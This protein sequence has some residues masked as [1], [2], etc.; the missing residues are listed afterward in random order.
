MNLLVRQITSALFLMIGLIASMSWF[1]WNDSPFWLLILGAIHGH[2]VW[3]GDVLFVY[4]FCAFILYFFRVNSNSNVFT[5]FCKA[6]ISINQLS[7]AK[8]TLEEAR[9]R[10]KTGTNLNLDFAIVYDLL[11]D[12]KNMIKEMLDLIED[13]SFYKN[14]PILSK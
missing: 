9:K 5:S 1:Y 12:E 3:Y 14:I 7:W 6:F 10:N 13:D 4:A 8:K 11:G 2:Y